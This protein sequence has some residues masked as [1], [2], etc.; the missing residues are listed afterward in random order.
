MR[1]RVFTALKARSHSFRPAAHQLP[2]PH[3]PPQNPPTQSNSQRGQ[4][5]AEYAIL[6]SGIAIVVAVMIP[7]L[8]S[9]VLGLFSSVASA[10]GG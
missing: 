2:P 8:G 10:F 5:V 3:M 4:T 9:A 7:L 6:I 1:E